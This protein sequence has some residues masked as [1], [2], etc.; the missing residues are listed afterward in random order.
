MRKELL[1]VLGRGQEFW[2]STRLLLLNTLA[3][4]GRTALSLFPMWL[5]LAPQVAGGLLT[6]G[7]CESPPH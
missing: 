5:L 4:K 7:C 3:G 1:D 2:L 6:A